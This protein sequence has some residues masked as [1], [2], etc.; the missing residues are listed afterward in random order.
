ME[1]IKKAYEEPQ[2]EVIRLEGADVICTS[3]FEAPTGP[4]AGFDNLGADN[5][6]SFGEF[7][8]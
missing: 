3:S 4:S 5:D 7:G 8:R 1:N 2:M 6:I